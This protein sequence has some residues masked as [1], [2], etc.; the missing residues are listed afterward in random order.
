[1][2]QAW[3]SFLPQFI[4]TRL[5]G[6]GILQK[7]IANTGWLFADKVLRVIVGVVVLISLARYLGPE[8]FGILNYSI[9]FV[10]LFTRI[11]TLGM[12]SIVV[13]DVVQDPMDVDRILGT[14]FFL[15]LIGGTAAAVLTI[16][17]IFV[18]RPGTR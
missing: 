18:L 9:A 10:A 1:M 5:E 11:A 12:D 3:V 8:R 2:N 13:R 7:A 15:R 16:G 14:G 4:R 6:R 17:T